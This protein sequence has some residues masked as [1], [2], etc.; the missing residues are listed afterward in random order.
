MKPLWKNFYR[1]QLCPTPQ[2]WIQVNCV[3]P[4]NNW[5]HFAL[6]P[7]WKYHGNIFTA[8]WKKLINMC[9][10]GFDWIV[11]RLQCMQF[12][13]VLL[14]NCTCNWM[15]GV[16]WK[17]QKWVWNV[18]LCKLFNLICLYYYSLLHFSTALNVKGMFAN[19]WILCWFQCLFV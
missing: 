1:W 9:V 5:L 14:D 3:S 11:H 4:V 17:C 2:E 15:A 19:C 12:V 18:A 10:P 16:K 13:V 8:L 7:Y 6:C